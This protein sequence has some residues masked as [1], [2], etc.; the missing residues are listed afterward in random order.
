[1]RLD[2]DDRRA[3][4]AALEAAIDDFAVVTVRDA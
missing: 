1:L 2:A 3:S 4:R